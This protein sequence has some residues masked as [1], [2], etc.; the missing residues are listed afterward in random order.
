MSKED[1]VVV[2]VV[3]TPMQAFQF[4]QFLKRSTFN[5]YLENATSEDEAYVQIE[6]GNRIRQALAEKG[7]APR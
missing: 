4:A 2:T 7:Y 6:A 3:L 5:Q 1:D